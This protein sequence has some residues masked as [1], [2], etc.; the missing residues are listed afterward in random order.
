LE[1]NVVICGL[2]N[3]LEIWNEEKWDAYKKD[4]EKQVDDLASKLGQL[5]I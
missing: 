4:A 5:G 2:S 1:K 3:R